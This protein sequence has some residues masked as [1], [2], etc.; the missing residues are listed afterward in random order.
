MRLNV[1]NVH[2][3]QVHKLEICYSALVALCYMY[4]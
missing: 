2:L 3:Y 4:I 1:L